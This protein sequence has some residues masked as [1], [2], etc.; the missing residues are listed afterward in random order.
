VA[1]TFGTGVGPAV[2]DPRAYP[3]CFL[4]EALDPDGSVSFPTTDD[5]SKY[6]ITSVEASSRGDG[7]GGIVAFQT[8]P[9][10]IQWWAITFGAGIETYQWRGALVILGTLESSVVAAS[11]TGGN[12][13]HLKICGFIIP[14]GLLPL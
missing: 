8:E 10:G 11:L 12:T 5:R 6:V 13:V 3:D 1:F 7:A 9:D 14:N 2:F 4:S